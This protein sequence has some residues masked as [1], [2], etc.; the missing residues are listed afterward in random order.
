MFDLVNNICAIPQLL[1]AVF[2]IFEIY[3][4][5]TLIK[6]ILAIIFY[7]CFY[8]LDHYI[9]IFAG[10]I[11]ASKGSV[12]SPIL[13]TVSGV[14]FIGVCIF[15]FLQECGKQSV[16]QEVLPRN[17]FVWG[18]KALVAL[19]FISFVVEQAVFWFTYHSFNVLAIKIGA[20]STIAWIV[21]IYIANTNIMK[22]IRF[23]RVSYS[24]LSA[25]LSVII[26][27]LFLSLCAALSEIYFGVSTYIDRT[28][29]DGMPVFRSGAFL[30]NPSIWAVWCATLGVISSFLFHNNKL[31]LGL[32]TV[33]FGL[34]A[35]CFAFSGSR[36][37]FFS[38]LMTLF[39]AAIMIRFTSCKSLSRLACITPLILQ[40][41]W[42]IFISIISSIIFNSLDLHNNLSASLNYNAIRIVE[43]PVELVKYLA[44]KSDLSSIIS[45]LN[46]FFDPYPSR[47]TVSSLEGRIIIPDL[48]QAG[49]GKYT[50]LDNVF[51]SFLDVA[52]QA[53][54][55]LWCILW[56]LV[57][58]IGIQSALESRGTLANVYCNSGFFG[59]ALIGMSMRITQ[60]FPVWVIFSFV[61]GCVLINFTASKLSSIADKN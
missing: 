27:P 39:I 33:I 52:G 18:V 40:I 22:N 35:A 42:M 37:V 10:I 6:I 48:S 36:S 12:P 9:M 1:L 15:K 50:N 20:T 59:F 31:K 26:V 25:F 54:F 17:S 16:S 29:L 28:I 51:L 5:T 53:G 34:E 49:R 58:I 56:L 60:L 61:T 57:M 21:A 13:A 7:S 3:R 45:N 24:T 4:E 11:D 30:M 44:F 38:Y 32:L 19:I 8:F 14:L 47:H 43:A 2:I 23:S 46:I 41:S 55:V